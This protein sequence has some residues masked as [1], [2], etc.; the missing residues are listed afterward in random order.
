M[1]NNVATTELRTII[2]VQRYRWSNGS[3]LAG[4]PGHDPFNSA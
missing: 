3:C 4:G 2:I 1:T